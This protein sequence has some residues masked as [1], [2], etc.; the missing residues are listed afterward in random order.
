MICCLFHLTRSVKTCCGRLFQSV[1]SAFV[2]V[3]C[4]WTGSEGHATLYWCF[5]FF[6]VAC[7]TIICFPVQRRR[8]QT[9]TAKMVSKTWQVNGWILSMPKLLDFAH[10]LC[11]KS[12]IWCLMRFWSSIPWMGVRVDNAP[13]CLVTCIILKACYWIL[14]CGC[15]VV[16][17]MCYLQAL[18]WIRQLRNI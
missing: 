12:L 15:S 17:K 3:A 13:Y 5:N 7:F 1:R 6:L 8:F 2:I 4:C 9:E 11:Q 10:F 16:G 18:S 14:W